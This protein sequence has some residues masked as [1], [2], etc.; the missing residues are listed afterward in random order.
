MCDFTLLL[1]Y[2]VIRALI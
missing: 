2:D 1:I